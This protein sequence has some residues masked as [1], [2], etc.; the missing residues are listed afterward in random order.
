MTG[1]AITALSA[2]G[3]LIILGIGY[4][5]A[6]PY[7]RLGIFSWLQSVSLMFPWLVFFGLFATGIYLNL[8]GILFL[9]VGSTATYILLG[10]EVRSLSQQAIAKQ[11]EELAAE[12]KINPNPINDR[13]AETTTDA[14]TPTPSD[15]TNPPAV[16][17]QGPN[18]PID[19]AL[20][21]FEP[22][23]AAD[24]AMAKEIFGIDSFFAT[25]TVPYQNGVI[26]NGNLRGDAVE[27]HTQLSD[28][29]A[30]RFN[31]RYRLFLIENPEGRPTVVVLPSENDP[32]PLTIA[33]KIVAIALG[34]ATIITCLE[35]SGFLLGFDFYQNISR[36]PE[37]LP[38]AS[39]LISV[40][41]IHEIGHWVA[42]R[43]YQ[44]KLS[45]PFF[46]PTWQIGA[47]GALTRFE[48]LLPNRNALFDI[49]FAGPLAGGGLSFIMLLIGLV[50][51]NGESS[52]QIPTIFFE[53]SILVGT[54]AKTLLHESLQQTMV[55]VHPL[56]VIGWIGLIYTAIN[57]MPAGCLDGGRMIQAIYGRRTARTT[58]IATF[59]LLAVISLINP[60]ALYWAILIL[61]LQRNLERPSLNEL[62]EPDDTRAGLA[63]IALFMM[64]TILLPLTP[65]LAGRL[66][67]GG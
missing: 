5:R 49:A 57:L 31:D 28:R 54:F 58:T 19:A 20:P 41:V 25:E 24:I 33:Q 8:V 30:T 10:R 37:V 26:F 39:G 67:I 32:K 55:N 18:S 12:A 53:G 48:S 60:L 6:R 15:A 38:L 43:R 56:V 65:S 64:I 59:I 51:S 29:L 40:L 42:A 63:L 16:K 27:V 9:L 23:P 35:T 3:A 17:A 45:W 11:S 14:A 34:I 1:D 22:M 61:F 4:Y 47:F 66:G 21:L 7:G 13:P 50:I 36:Y 46:L 62:T 52:F 44:V 2:L